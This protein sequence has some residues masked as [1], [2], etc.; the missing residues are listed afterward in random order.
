VAA[1][2]IDEEKLLPMDL[3]ARFTQIWHLLDILSFQLFLQSFVVIFLRVLNVFIKLF[4][5]EGWYL[6]M[7]TAEFSS[8]SFLVNVLT[9]I[10]HSCFH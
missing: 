9:P 8:R 4:H 5:H 1:S 7:G 10:S 2:S 3:S 6:F